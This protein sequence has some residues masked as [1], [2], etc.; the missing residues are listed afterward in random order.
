MSTASQEAP[1]VDRIEQAERFR[2]LHEGPEPLLIP[3][4]WDAGSAKLLVS[5]GFRAVATTSSGFK[6]SPPA[7]HKALAPVC[8]R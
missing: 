6:K 1:P 5:L 3:N 2:A 4:A 8:P 7:K